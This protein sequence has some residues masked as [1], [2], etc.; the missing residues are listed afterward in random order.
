MPSLWRFEA[1]SAA[2]SAGLSQTGC[3]RRSSTLVIATPSYSYIK[4]LKHLDFVGSSGF[5]VWFARKKSVESKQRQAKRCGRELENI[6]VGHLKKP[7]PM[8]SNA[9]GTSI[10][11]LPAFIIFTVGN[12]GSSALNFPSDGGNY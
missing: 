12:K 7:S 11:R 5:L 4:Y 2:S 3:G 1:K 6:A 10:P 8:M 9:T